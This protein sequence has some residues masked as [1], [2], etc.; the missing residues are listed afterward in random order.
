MRDTSCVGLSVSERFLLPGE[1]YFDV[2]PIQLSTLLGSCVSLVLWHPA[3]HSGGMCH[4]KL[5]R[6]RARRGECPLDGSYAEHVEPIIAQFLRRSRRHASEYRCGVYGGGQMFQSASGCMDIGTANIAAAIDVAATLG[7]NLHE[8]RTGG[9]I[10]RKL[11][12]DMHTGAVKLSESRVM[13]TERVSC[14][15]VPRGR[16]V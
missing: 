4:I 14:P 3:D 6:V 1:Y 16:L 12:F 9:A 10:Y 2:I 5:P 8:Q 13:A 15:I 7:L 11:D